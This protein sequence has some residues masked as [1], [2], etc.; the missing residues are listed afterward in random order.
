MARPPWTFQPCEA[1]FSGCSANRH[2]HY[3]RGIHVDA[4]RAAVPAWGKEVKVPVKEPAKPVPLEERQKR[5]PGA[6][7]AVCCELG[8]YDL[9]FTV[10]CVESFVEQ[11][12]SYGGRIRS[13]KELAELGH[14]LWQSSP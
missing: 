5:V 1:F 14:R 4:T 2:Q 12:H 6:R 8:R 11:Y 9:R 7:L 13:A 3:G 10:S